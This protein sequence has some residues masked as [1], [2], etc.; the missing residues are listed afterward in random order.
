MQ[1][2]HADSP[3]S[4]SPSVII[5]KTRRTFRNKTVA[6]GADMS[7]NT[8]S[9]FTYHDD[10]IFRTKAV[11]TITIISTMISALK[12]QQHYIFGSCFFLRSTP[13]EP[14]RRQTLILFSKSVSNSLRYWEKTM[15]QRCQKTALIQLKLP[16]VIQKFRS[17]YAVHSINFLL[18][19]TNLKRFLL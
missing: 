19:S 18:A 6:H 2:S 1:T 17:L 7:E 9:A 13:H 14:S 4:P 8:R 10:G 12:R 5:G 11:L 16:E 15:N 3:L